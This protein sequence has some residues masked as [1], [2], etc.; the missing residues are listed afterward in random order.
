MSSPKRRIETDVS[1]I[2][3]Q[4]V[5][6]GIMVEFADLSS[7]ITAATGDEVCYPLLNLV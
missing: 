5:L 7:P 1:Y 2:Q 4:R 6:V 3:K